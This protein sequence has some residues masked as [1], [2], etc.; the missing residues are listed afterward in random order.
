MAAAV[1]TSAGRWPRRRSGTSTSSCPAPTTRKDAKD[2]LARVR[3]GS[4]SFLSEVAMDYVQRNAERHIKQWDRPAPT[5]PGFTR[6]YSITVPRTELRLTTQDLTGVRWSADPGHGYW[7]RVEIILMDPAGV[8][9]EVAWDEAHRLGMLRL[10]NGDRVIVVAQRCRPDQE[11][12]QKLGAYRDMFADKSVDDLPE[13][14]SP[15]VGLH[16]HQE[17]GARTLTELAMFPASRAVRVICTG[18]PLGPPG[19]T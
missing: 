9:T 4:H 8:G 18:R 5:I 13:E 16:G 7:V 15:V 6:V 17:D 10:K 14:G 12:A 11:A 19:P 3:T 1:C 2:Q